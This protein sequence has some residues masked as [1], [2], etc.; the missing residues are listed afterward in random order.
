MSLA[1]SESL[2]SGCNTSWNCTAFKSIHPSV[3]PIVDVKS[4]N[5]FQSAALHGAK[6]NNI[7]RSA[8]SPPWCWFILSASNKQMATM[9]PKKNKKMRTKLIE[10]YR[11]AVERTN[12][13]LPK[14][15]FFTITTRHIVF[16][17]PLHEATAFLSALT[18]DY[19]PLCTRRQNG[20]DSRYQ[21]LDLLMPPLC[22]QTL[23]K[24]LAT[25]LCLGANNSFK[26]Q[27][28][29]GVIRLELGHLT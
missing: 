4:Y 17:V 15:C 8:S 21:L 28:G 14:L 11:A 25:L 26:S 20:L 5:N 7:S 29:Q 6:K 18:T 9:P 16:A 1:L 27:R 2:H 19:K 3:S 10:F 12:L 22:L 23:V 24:S 13:R